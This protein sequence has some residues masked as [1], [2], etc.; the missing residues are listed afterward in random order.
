MKRNSCACPGAR[1]K[2]LVLTA[3][4]F[5]GFVGLCAA[6]LD[7]GY[8]F[9]PEASASPEKRAEAVQEARFKVL[10][11]AE[12]YENTP[13][14]YGGADAR[15]LDCSGLIYVS[16]QDALG[17]AT[18]R[19]TTALYAWV[20]KIPNTELQPG[21]LLF[22]K[23]DN[24]GKISHA[25]IFAGGGRFIHSTSQG[26]ATGVIYSSLDEAYWASRYAGGG[27]ALP[28]ADIDQ[29][30]TPASSIAA[31]GADRENTRQASGARVAGVPGSAGVPAAGGAN[32][33]RANS[34]PNTAST[35][36]AALSAGGGGPAPGAAAEDD[37]VPVRPDSAPATDNGVSG[38]LP[39]K[40]GRFLLGVAAAPSWGGLLE[41]GLLQGGSIFRGFTS[42]FRG[43]MP[44]TFFDKTSLFGAEIR[45]EYD[46]A[47]GVF[48]LPFTLSWGFDDRFRVFAGPV[49]SFGDA[50]LRTSD[51][52]RRYTGGTSF[53]G[54]IGITVAPFT[55]KVGGGELAP[56]GELAWQSYINDGSKPNIVA[57]FAAGIRFST[58]IR[59]TWK[60]K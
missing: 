16:F 43:A 50:E 10:S 58:G 39:E 17:V 49:I 41:D 28:A 56:Y 33:P 23:T 29:R 31:P 53:L 8:A 55:F 54:T 5:S 27:R 6:P 21:D 14:R 1:G 47:L 18:P 48:R 4:I 52:V 44:F 35:R 20:E 51:G 40:S 59:F 46:A 25:G 22:F 9:A 26:P 38:A 2:L 42:Q 30:R 34:V 19:S 37:W 36:P 32:A 45:P 57:D 7:A 24:S 3:L 15:G 13:Y 11:A 12:K 60:V